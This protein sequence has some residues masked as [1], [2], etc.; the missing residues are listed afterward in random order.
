MEIIKIDN[1]SFQYPVSL[2]ENINNINLTVNKGEF[3]V[4]CG[5][6]GS[7]KTT[8]LRL[9]KPA[10]SPFGE[11]SGNI[12]IHE[13]DINTLTSEEVAS[14]I[15]FVM[16]NPESQI[17]TDKVWHELAF[18]LESL[19]YEN[20]Y[21]KRRVSEMASYFGIHTWFH[22]K[23]C[24]LS[25]G[26][27]QLL[28]LASVMAM[29]PEI[30][31][32]DEPTGQLDPLSASEFLTA[33]YKLNRELGITVIISEHRLEELF[34]KA[35]RIV[36]MKNGS[37][38]TE[39]KPQNIEKKLR[40]D[41]EL[42]KLMP[43]FVRIFASVKEDNKICPVN[44]QEARNWLF[45]KEI[46]PVLY[47]EETKNG[48]TI[49][50][51]KDLHV[52]YEKDGDSVIKGLNLKVYENEIISVVG[53]NGAG[54]TTLLSAIKN[55]VPKTSGSIKVDNTLKITALSQNPEAM[56]LKNTVEKDLFDTNGKSE[57]EIK[58][59]IDFC[60]LDGLLKSH[61]FDLSGGEKQRVAFAKV[62][63]ADGD[64]ILLDE[65][66]KGM[67]QEF[68]EKF[69]GMLKALKNKGKTIIMVSHD[70]EFCAEYSDRVGMFFDGQITGID[71]PRKFFSENIFYTTSASRMSRD[72]IDNAVLTNDVITAIGGKLPEKK[73]IEKKTIN[74]PEKKETQI[75]SECK[76]RKLNKRTFA[77]LLI[78]LI[79]IPVTV[80]CG[81]NFLDDRKYYFISLLIILE[82][83][84]PFAMIFEKRKPKAREI[85]IIAVLCAIAIGSRAAFYILHQFKPIVAIIIISAIC[86]G[87]ETGF[88]VGAVTAFVSN[89][90]FGQGPWAPWQMFALG[91]IGF[92]AGILSDTGLLSKSKVP[93]CIFGG[94]A[95]LIIYGGIMNPA[96]VFI[97]NQNP[98]WE[99]IV[100]A[101]AA[102][103]PYDMVHALATVFFLWFIAEPM[104][105]K[106]ERLKLKYGI[107]EG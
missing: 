43:S 106:L 13:R 92:V 107:N 10:I 44:T 4:L 2:K 35:D 86:F 58:E 73:E 101:Y 85:A 67:D 8:L 22:K 96:S 60:E 84:I 70:V 20:S 49:I 79:L 89:M 56:F 38:V 1:L 64:I 19:G 24:E 16:Q 40:E 93:L 15:G 28:N 36:V 6:S 99:M 88:L 32:L 46:T 98:T 69:G 21:I 54:K 62:L 90:F 102:G 42:L 7:G 34:D 29:N 75:K 78:L 41:E 31:I 27:K 103:L 5:K 26:Q 87:G 52:K 12:Y 45:D 14:K 61:P 72:I 30:L 63:I 53:G 104:T 97:W 91:M 47:N 17:V 57:E 83:L 9:L 37:I 51:I 66:T 80:Y 71:T 3:I 39:D 105:E 11:K 95:T 59:I 50:D 25:G 82:T 74:K 18:G 100:S 23:T 48:K 77:M 33:V 55:T 65:P 76:K 94:F 68:K 81:I